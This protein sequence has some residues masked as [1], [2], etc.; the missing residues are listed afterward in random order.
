MKWRC[1][2]CGIRRK[3]ECLE[4]W[5]SCKQCYDQTLCTS[6]YLDYLEGD[7]TPKTTP[8]SSRVLQ[9][10]E[11]EMKRIREVFKDLTGLGGRFFGAACGW[12]DVNAEWLDEKAKEYDEWEK[13]YNDSG[14]FNECPRPGQEF[15]KLIKRCG[16]PR[17]EIMRK[18]KQKRKESGTRMLTS[19]RVRS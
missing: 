8:K 3:H 6:C 17:K 9:D 10:L 18:E 14:R 15:L 13:S 5:Y 1:S 7:E 2:I 12:V 11:D 4:K 19:R 16:R